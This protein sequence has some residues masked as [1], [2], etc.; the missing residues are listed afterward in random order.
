MTMIDGLWTVNDTWKDEIDG[1]SRWKTRRAI[2]STRK[3]TINARRRTCLFSVA[4]ITV[5]AAAV[6]V[7]G[8][9][10]RTVHE[11]VHTAKRCRIRVLNR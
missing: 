3:T 10:R 1:R 2:D 4:S 7:R 5:V 11:T 8:C 9:V 6:G